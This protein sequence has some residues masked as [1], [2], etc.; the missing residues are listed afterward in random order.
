MRRFKLVLL[1]GSLLLAGI[2][3]AQDTISNANSDSY[4]FTPIIELPVT[5]V[6]DQNKSGTCWAY[7]TIS[8]LESELLRMGKPEMDLSEMFA[9]YHC[10]MAKADKYVR[11]H[12]KTNFS[13]GGAFHDVIWAL[14]NYGMVPQSAYSGL[15]I[16]EEKPVHSEMDNAL[17]GY[18]D[19]IVKNPNKKLTP[20]WPD[21]VEGMLNDYLGQIPD[22]FTYN[23]VSYTPRS[24]ADD[25]LKINPDDYIEIG[26]YTHHPFYSKFAIEIPD[27]W[28]WNEIYNLPL[29][30]MMEI[31]DNALKNGYTIAWGADASDR[32]FATK[33]KGVAVVPEADTIDMSKKEFSKWEKLDEKEKDDELFKLDKP[34]NEKVITQAMRQTD[35]DNY[36]STDDH[37]MHIIG[38]ATDQNGTLYYK[39]KNSWG[40][41][42][43]YG[44]FFY[45]SKSY[46]ELRTIDI[47]VNKEA[48]PKKIR[49]KLGIN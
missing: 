18:V 1:T 6:K 34:G 2:V 15:N 20:V 41:Y 22:T 25:Y 32:G 7:S 8:F 44:G 5:P 10:Y 48:I 36:T 46:V 40:D 37:G 39:V 14:K 3:N 29:E 28:M 33:K 31:I 19:G 12:G 27:N 38:T 21:V 49:L 4:Q 35:F 47:M 17:R 43:S 24:F 13:S 16:G 9:V 45:A 26:S 23:G 30:D 42:N 11:M